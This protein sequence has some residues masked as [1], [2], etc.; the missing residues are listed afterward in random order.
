VCAATRKVHSAR[1][2]AVCNARCRFMQVRINKERLVFSSH[3]LDIQ[4]LLEQSS[5]SPRSRHGSASC[6]TT[7]RQKKHLW[8]VYHLLRYESFLTL[9]QTTDCVLCPRIKR[10][11]AR[12]V[13]FPPPDSYLRVCKPTEG[14]GW[15][16]AVCSV[17]MPETTFTDDARLRLV[18]G[19]A[20]IPPLRWSRVS[21]T[22][23]SSIIAS[24]SL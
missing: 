11:Q 2:F 5:N 16:H 3:N 14:Q 4:E 19:I 9:A 21:L 13:T 22:A 18:E 23:Y 10:T 1:S 24:Y 17:F 6:V 12:G 20:S 7:R 8:L 15:A